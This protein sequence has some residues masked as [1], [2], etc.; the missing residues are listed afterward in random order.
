MPPSLINTDN[1]GAMDTQKTLIRHR[2]KKLNFV[3]T[4]VLSSIPLRS[5]DAKSV[6]KSKKVLPCTS[7]LKQKHNYDVLYMKQII[8]ND[9]QYTLEVITFL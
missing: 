2:R 9:L 3:G 5:K 6:C 7:S 4:E 1:H 8:P